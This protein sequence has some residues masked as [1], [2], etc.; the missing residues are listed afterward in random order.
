MDNRHI[1]RKLEHIEIIIK[2]DVDHPDRCKAFFDSVILVH[3]AL[4]LLSFKE[5]DTS[6]TFLGRIVEAPV[7]I[8]G[9]TGGHPDTIPINEKLARIAEE[10]RIP[11]GLGS[12]RP[13]FIKKGDR[14]IAESYRVVRRIARDV[15]VVGNIGAV[16]LVGIESRDI[17]DIVNEFELDGLAIHFN[18]AQEAIQEEGDTDFTISVFERVRDLKKAIG[19]PLILKEVGNGFS[20]EFVGLFYSNGF[21]MFDISGACGTNWITVEKYRLRNNNLKARVADVL[22]SWGIPTPAS[23]IEA[24]YAAPDSFIIA[25]GG[26][27]DGLRAAKMLSLGADMVGLAKPVL[28]TLLLEGYEKALDFL[29]SYILTLKTVM[30]LTSS[31]KPVD[32]R[33]RPVVIL[34]PLLEYIKQRGIDI[35]E[36]LLSR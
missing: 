25:S 28:K 30:F 10:L 5:V 3:Q 4:P 24:R 11:I 18:P 33:K 8:T 22:S 26:V 19:V 36:Y 16:N 35:N 34:D 9:M 1:D 6:T 23:L 21:R 14:Q 15:P 20:K 32:L 2:E 29:K 12:M 31:K 13:L 7:M 27:W 17:Q